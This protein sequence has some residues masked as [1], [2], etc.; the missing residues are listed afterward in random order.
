[1]A[2]GSG[3]GRVRRGAGVWLGVRDLVGSGGVRACG[4]G[5][6]QGLGGYF[7]SNPGASTLNPEHWA[8]DPG[9]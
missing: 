3:L 9:L 4:L 6:G 7:I 1:V 8:L 2:W 5:F